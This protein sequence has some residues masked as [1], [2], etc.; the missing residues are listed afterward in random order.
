MSIDEIAVQLANPQTQT[1]AVNFVARSLPTAEF[2]L[3]ALPHQNVTEQRCAV[4]GSAPPD[5]A[6]GAHGEDDKLGSAA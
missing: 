2:Q 6:V 4:T 1:D 3:R 5:R